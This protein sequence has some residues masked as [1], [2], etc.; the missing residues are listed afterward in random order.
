M[1]QSLASPAHALILVVAIMFSAILV[2][3]NTYETRAMTREFNQ[4]RAD[5]TRTQLRWRELNL[6]HSSRLSHMHMEQVARNTL[7][8]RAPHLGDS[9]LIRL[10][11]DF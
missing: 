4:L 6:E 1:Y 9:K 11:K 8:M 7:D 3:W 2:V 10:G 5:L